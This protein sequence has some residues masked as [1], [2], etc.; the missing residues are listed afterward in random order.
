MNNLPKNLCVFIL[1]GILFFSPSQNILFAE[2]SSD[3][4]DKLNKEF[5]LNFGDDFVDVLA[6]PKNWK[7]GDFL[8]LS[9][10]LGAGLLLY[11]VDQDIQQWAQDHRS[12]SSE[13][14]FKT[15]GQLGNGVVLIGLMTALYVSGEVSDNNSLRKTALLS[16]ESW[17]TSGIIVRGLKSVVGR[18]R[19]WTG[20]SSHSFHPFS[21]RS[22]FASFPSGHA[23]SAF[24]VATVIADQ[25]KKVY[26]DILAYSLATMAAFSRVHLD[27]HWA[28][29]ILVGSAIG[30]FVAKKIS[31]LDRNR[32][33]KKVKLSFQ[34]SRQRQAFSLTYYF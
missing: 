8:S 30:Y 2:T 27:K 17:L 20:E 34:F 18:A 28:S 15:I 19:P 9:A 26:I 16:L 4:E 12:S 14:S 23:S 31:A 21:T 22:R 29:D 1:L 10:V 24:A 25:S 7:G 33:S 11:S 32:D 13:D 3:D 6:S 5:L